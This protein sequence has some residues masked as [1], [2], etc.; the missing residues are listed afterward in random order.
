MPEINVRAVHAAHG[1]DACGIAQAVQTA[2]EYGCEI[3]D[4][5]ARTIAALFHSG[6]S[7]AGYAFASSGAISDPTDVYRSLFKDY[8]RADA[9]ERLAGDALGTYLVQAGVRGPVPGWSEHWVRH[10]DCGADHV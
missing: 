3:D 8:D 7:T 9:F 1:S 4:G 5:T 6:Q 2:L 10:G